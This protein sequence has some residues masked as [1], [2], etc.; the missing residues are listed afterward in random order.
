[1][2]LETLRDK[3]GHDTVFAYTSAHKIETITDQEGNQTSHTYHPNG[4]LWT[5]TDGEQKTTTMLYDTWGGLEKIIAHDNTYRTFINN[6]RGDVL[7]AT[8]EESRKTV[9][10]YN[11]RRQLLTSTL[12]P[13]P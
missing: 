10:T 1:M 5:V 2:R 6:A 3:R 4:L 7:E 9:Q 8:D 11:N 12:P 13:V